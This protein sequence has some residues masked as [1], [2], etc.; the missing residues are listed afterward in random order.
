MRRSL[1][2]LLAAGAAGGLAAA[3]VAGFVYSGFYNVAATEQHTA[4]VYFLIEKVMRQS[5]LER[6]RG[7]T[8][9]TLPAGALARGLR[10]YRDHCVRCHG[11]PGVAPEPFA[12]SMTPAPAALVETARNW[13]AAEIHWAVRYGIKMTGMPAWEYRLGEQELWEVTA[14]VETLPTL[15]PREYQAMANAAGEGH[16][17]ALPPAPRAPDAGRGREALQ[18]YACMT[19]HAIPGIVGGDRQVGPPFAGIAKRKYLAGMLT[20]TPENLVR[21]IRF[22]QQVD[23]LSAMPDLRVTENDA[24]DMAAYLQ[25]LDEQP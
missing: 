9:P 3:G 18:Q 7:Q 4:P 8:V 25:T 17:H 6:T 11:A 13:T 22:P 21:W 1:R 16:A 14:F 15:S 23:P 24:R 20:N 2:F 10:L 12:L 5:I 19:C